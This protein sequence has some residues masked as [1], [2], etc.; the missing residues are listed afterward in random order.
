M[1]RAWGFA[2]RDG[3]FPP[4]DKLK[5]ALELSGRRHLRL[6]DAAQT[7]AFDAEGVELN[8]GAI[9]KGIALDAAAKKLRDRGVIDYLIQGGKSGA[10][11]S[12]GRFD[13]YAPNV[14]APVEEEEEDPDFD[15]ESGLPR[16]NAPTA[17]ESL[18]A[19]TPEAFKPDEAL[20]LAKRLENEPIGWTIGVAHPLAPEKRLG[21][22]WLRDC[23]LA[24]SGS[25][26][27]FFRAGGKRYSHIIDPRTG[28][29]TLGVLSTTVLA[30]TATE[31]DALSTAF[32]V[33]GPDKT[34]E[35]CARRPDV[36]ALLVVEREK[37]PG[38]EIL[39]FNLGPDVF[40]AF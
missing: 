40:R 32:F 2:N 12:G 7:V 26:Y 11:A 20:L 18:D 10:V 3:E 24:T 4:E 19:L 1:W 8:F 9:G 29:P 35:F 14:I 21:E 34:E 6:D 37:D 17:K 22:L 38:Y 13:D 23:A 28:M 33:L 15:E 39:T 36:A 16:R 31:A 25:T 5:R 30:P 27:Q